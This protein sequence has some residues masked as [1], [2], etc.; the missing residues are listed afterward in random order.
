MLGLILTTTHGCDLTDVLATRRF[1]LPVKVYSETGRSSVEILVG[2]CSLY[3]NYL[4]QS[5]FHLVW[6]RRSHT[7]FLVLHP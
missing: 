6:E 4:V 5:S 3:A 1:A 7:S 2:E